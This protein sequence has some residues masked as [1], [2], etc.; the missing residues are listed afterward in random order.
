MRKLLGKLG[1][2]IVGPLLRAATLLLLFSP[3]FCQAQ[4]DC[5]YA[6]PTIK[7]VTPTTWVAGKTTKVTITGTNLCWAYPWI[8][9]L[10]AITERSLG[11]TGGRQQRR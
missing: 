3:V 5:W 8:E 7:D 10:T 4:D 11:L 2:I 6:Q 9:A 1:G